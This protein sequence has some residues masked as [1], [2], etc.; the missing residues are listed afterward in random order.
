[1]VLNILNEPSP[2]SYWNGLDVETVLL[3]IE[4]ADFS[5]S[6]KNKLKYDIF[7]QMAESEK[8]REKLREHLGSA[9]PWL[10][11]C[12]YSE[13]VQKLLSL[14]IAPDADHIDEMIRYAI[15]KQSY[16]I[17]LMLTEYKRKYIGYRNIADTL[18]L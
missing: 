12:N 2:Y 14:R 16:D 18:K 15:D 10:I 13:G 5:I 17:Q 4:H 6:I 3:L 9:L 11:D 7:L 8:H 1:M